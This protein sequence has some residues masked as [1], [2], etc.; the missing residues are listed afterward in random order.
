MLFEL[1]LSMI[2]M[3]LGVSG[4]AKDQDVASAFVFLCGL[5]VFILVL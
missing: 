3:A 2:L 5:V 1:I 4:F